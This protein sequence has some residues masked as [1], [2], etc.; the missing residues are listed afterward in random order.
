MKKVIWILAIII[1]AIIVLFGL[2]FLLGGSE[3]TWI[4]V[5]KEWVKHGVPYA[6]K[7]LTGCGDDKGKEDEQVITNFEECIEAGNPAMESYP[8]Q[9]RANNETFTEDIGNELEKT[10]LI[11]ID[12]PRPNQ[13]I[14]SPL[15]IIGQARGYWFFEADFPVRLLDADNNELARGIATAKASWMTDDFVHFE[16]ELEFN[17]PSAKKGML[18][19]EKDNPS[20][21]LEN[22]DQLVVPVKFTD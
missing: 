10:D 11:R 9:C 17:A 16:A 21:L 8:R 2:R 6:P 13:V 22:D 3:D 5:D 12:S 14:K 18:I 1:L 7:P 15:T 20:G 19:L 4:C